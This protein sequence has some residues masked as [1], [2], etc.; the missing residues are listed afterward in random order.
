MLFFVE[1][2]PTV[3]ATLILGVICLFFSFLV[4][5]FSL[6]VSFGVLF[7]ILVTNPDVCG[8]VVPLYCLVFVCPVGELFLTCFRDVSLTLFYFSCSVDL[9]IKA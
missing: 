3:R 2:N 5:L 6:F 8:L 9:F 4:V 1:L 7:V